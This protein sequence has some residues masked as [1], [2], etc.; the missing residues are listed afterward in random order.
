MTELQTVTRS[1]ALPVVMTFS[2]T[3][4]VLALLG[5]SVA[6]GEYH[7]FE[8]E[9]ERQGGGGWPSFTESTKLV[10]FLGL[11]LAIPT[12]GFGLRL[13]RNPECRLA[14]ILWYCSAVILAHL[15]WL[16]VSFLSVYLLY[17]KFY[18]WL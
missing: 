15:L 1:V 4:V 11:V 17:V 9:A 18:H 7:H 2:I 16:V 3:S 6:P 13:L 14:T 10:P 8:H 5:A 12:F